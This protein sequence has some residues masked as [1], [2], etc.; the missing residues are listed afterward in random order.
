M[1]GVKLVDKRTTV[2]LMD[3]L[4]LKE[5]ADK[6]ARGNGVRCYGYV[7]RQP[8]EDVV[9]LFDCYIYPPDSQESN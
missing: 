9:F 8:E 4:G 3:T 6:L 1:C 2:E 7:L 5:T